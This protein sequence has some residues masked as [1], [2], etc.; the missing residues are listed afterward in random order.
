MTDATVGTS[1]PAQPF[2]PSLVPGDVMQKFQRELDA[3]TVALENKLPELALQARK[4]NE[5]LRQWP[6]IGVLLTDEQ[7]GQ[8]TRVIIQESHIQFSMAATSGRQGK[9][10]D[11]LKNVNLDALSGSDVQ[12]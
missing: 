11:P 10:K 1:N 4:V 7:I 8:F 2:V 6:E 3:M 5:L 9:N 12:I